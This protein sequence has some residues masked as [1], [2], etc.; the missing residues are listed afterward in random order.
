MT[1]T[2]TK[3]TNKSFLSRLG[4]F[5]PCFSLWIEGWLWIRWVMGFGWFECFLFFMVAGAMKKLST[6][7]TWLGTH[8]I[9]HGSKRSNLRKGT[10]K[11]KIQPF[12]LIKNLAKQL[13]LITKSILKLNDSERKTPGG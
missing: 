9:V 10:L 3:H 4:G 13:I 12:V 2:A 6:A 5:L 1:S 8:I 7:I 11:L